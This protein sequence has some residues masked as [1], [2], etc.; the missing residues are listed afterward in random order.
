MSQSTS[1]RDAREQMIDSHRLISGLKHAL[2]V[3]YAHVINEARS[4]WERNYAG[5]DP[6]DACVSVRITPVDSRK[7]VL[8]CGG[9]LKKPSHSF[10]IGGRRHSVA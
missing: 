5:K 1:T 6:S 2:D 10:L 8:A 3:N 9:I 7:R 4:R